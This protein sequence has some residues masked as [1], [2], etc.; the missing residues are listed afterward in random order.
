[1]TSMAHELNQ[2]LN[3][4]STY[5]YSAKISSQAGNFAGVNQSLGYIEGLAMRMGKI[6]SSL[7]SFAKKSDDDQPAATQNLKD[8][9][10][11]AMTIVIAKARRQMVEIDNQLTSDLTVH[12]NALAIEQVL[13]NLL[14]NSCDAIDE[15]N[16]EKRKITIRAVYE[17]QTHHAIGIFDSGNGFDFSIIDKL[18]TPFTTTKEVGLGLGLNISKSLMEKHSGQIYLASN[19]DKGALVILELLH[20][21]S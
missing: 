10:D 18:F 19:L 17:T 15:Q 2:P 3:A 21:K 8:I 1:M 9:A 6:I 13:V 4:M 12:G 11:Q 16:G 14:V 20:A 7:R 5:L